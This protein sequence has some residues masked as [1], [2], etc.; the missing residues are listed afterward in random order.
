MKPRT[1]PP[2]AGLAVA[3]AAPGPD[4]CKLPAHQDVYLSAGFGYD[5]NCAPAVGTL[6]GLMLFVDFDDAPATGAGLDTPEA[7]RDFFLPAAADWYKT[8]SYG[9]L[10]LVVDART[11]AGFARMPYNASAYGY[12][13]GMSAGAQ[14]GYIADALA[15]SAGALAAA[16]DLPVDVLYV[17]PTRAARDIDFSTT[18][19]EAIAV[20][21]A[22]GTGT[23]GEVR[24]A[25]KAVTLGQDAVDVWGGPATLNHETGH[26][27]CLPDYYPFDGRPAGTYTGGWGLMGLVAA[28]APDY[29]AWDKWRLGWL[30]DDQVACVEQQESSSSSS[31]SHLLTPLETGGAGLKAVVVVE[32]HGGSEA[33]VA[34]LRSARGLDGEVCAPGVLL[35]TVST[36]TP[37]G[38]GP[39][40]VLDANPLSGGCA[41]EEL[42]DG[43]LTL[44]GVSSFAVPGWGVEVTVTKESDEGVEIRVDLV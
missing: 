38:E 40:R 23:G 15:A 28:P 42:S 19:A 2:A 41:G 3:A 31:S 8:A 22:N 11:Q 7:L 5:H 37:T 33:L 29:L 16:D 32:R 43:T 13:R 12:D 25:R 14:L 26:A 17:V 36:T 4:A 1:L 9:A 35:Y 20:P 10:D 6:R 18:Y 34:E 39:V 44:A 21:G 27:L 30:A 24:V